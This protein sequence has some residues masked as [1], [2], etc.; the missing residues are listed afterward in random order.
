MEET[1][2]AAIVEIRVKARVTEKSTTGAKRR[3]IKYDAKSMKDNM[4]S[5]STTSKRKR[6]NKHC[7]HETCKGKKIVS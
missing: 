3:N 4:S 2:A 7:S 1:E 5:V 6:I